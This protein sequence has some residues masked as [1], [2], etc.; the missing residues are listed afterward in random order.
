MVQEFGKEDR[1]RDLVPEEIERIKHQTAYIKALEEQTRTSTADQHLNAEINRVKIAAEAEIA[2]AELASVKRREELVLADDAYA[3]VYHFDESVNSKSVQECMARLNWWTR[4][5][6]KCDIT[7]IISSPG[8]SITD[9]FVLYDYLKQI[10][11]KGHS[12]HCTVLGMAASMAGVLLQAGT[13]RS[14]GSESWLLIHEGGYGAQGSAG[15]M[16]DMHE[17]FKKLKSRILDIYVSRAAAVG[18]AETTK[19]FIEGKWSR[20][21]WWISASEALEYGFIDE[22]V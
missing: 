19:T 18:K 2:Q 9:G 20:K 1:S 22:I 12:V 17:Y 8:G 7:I 5:K 21:D 4:A 3:H 10:Q 13:P 11:K 15:A 6:E 14:M 16:E